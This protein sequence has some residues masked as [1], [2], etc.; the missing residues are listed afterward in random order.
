MNDLDRSESFASSNSPAE[1]WNNSWRSAMEE[2]GERLQRFQHAAQELQETVNQ[3]SLKQIHDMIDA[4]SQIS[5]ALNEA[6]RDNSFTGLVNAQP[7]VFEHVMQATRKSN[8]RLLHITER[9]NACT[10][11]MANAGS[12]EISTPAGT[13]TGEQAGDAERSATPARNATASQK[14]KQAEARPDS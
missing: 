2:S 13:D 8:Q 1:L 4:M 3:E 12:T 14:G 9:M 7:K 6:S 5:H 10:I 11:S